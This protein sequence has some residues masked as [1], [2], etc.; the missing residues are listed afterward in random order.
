MCK[1]LLKRTVCFLFILSTIALAAQIP[2]VPFRQEYH[3]PHAIG[4]NSKANDVRAIA[5]DQQDNVWAATGNGVY[6]LPAGQNQWIELMNKSDLG[7][8]F[9]VTVDQAGTVWAGCWNGLYR[10]DGFKLVKANEVKQPIGAIG[11]V[12]EKLIAMGPD[13]VRILADGKWQ[14]REI[15][16]ARTVRNIL[17]DRKGGYWMA[18]SM[19]LYHQT[20]SGMQLLQ[21]AD[22]LLSADVYDAAYN[23][24]DYLWI[25]GLG[26][27]T[28]YRNGRRIK[29]IT[30][31]QGLPGIYIHSVTRGPDGRMWVGTDRGVARFDGA[32]WSLRHSRRWLL[33][34]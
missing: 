20:Q 30:P 26:G 9:A 16:C 1:N 21:S 18:T 7:P 17:S 2:D 13:G 29:D 12:D 14:K 28:V 3:V 27:I 10:S 6:L 22:E 23:V 8:A 5:V 15:R 25:G 34:D 11:V 31:E 4:D 19:G 33:D 32:S 24:D